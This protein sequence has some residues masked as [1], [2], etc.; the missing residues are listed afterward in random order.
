M[1]LQT[2][3]ENLLT[4]FVHQATCFRKGQNSSTLDLILATEEDIVQDVQYLAPIGHSDHATLSFQIQCNCLEA[5]CWPTKRNYNKGDYERA[6]EL[7]HQTDWKDM[8]EGGIEQG[9]HFFKS[10][11]DEICKE[12]IPLQQ[13]KHKKNM[14]MNKEAFRLKNRKDK[15]FRKFMKTN[16][17]TDFQRYKTSR[18]KL[19]SFT[20]KLRSSFEKKLTG[21]LKSDP[22]SFWQYCKSKAKTQTKIDKF[23][24]ED[25]TEAKL[26]KEKVIE[27]NNF[28]CS[29]F[30]KEDMATLPTVALLEGNRIL[31]DIIITR[32]KIANKLVK[33]NKSKAPGPDGVHPSI[34][35]EQMTA[36]EM[37]LP[38][39][40]LF[41]KSMYEV[42]LPSDWKLANISPIY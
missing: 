21:E 38:L 35:R 4:K 12:V 37:S 29:V 24:R 13:T 17:E 34:L 2:S 40:I 30:T 10:R 5:I 20:R 42:N 18:N 25:G 8:A 3:Q 22:K 15:H 23:V 14:Y 6:K 41:R 28:F 26:P 19:R 11:M 27:L 1:F 31:D 7:I 36:E 32:E 33:L 39:S 9:W 16:S